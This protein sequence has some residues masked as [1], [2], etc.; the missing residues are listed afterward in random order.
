MLGNANEWVNDWYSE[1]YYSTLAD[2]VVNPQGPDSG[3]TRGIR[4]SC[5]YDENPA[6]IHA[7]FRAHAD[8]VK[9]D[10][11]RCGGFRCGRSDQPD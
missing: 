9:N 4:G 5:Y 6:F 11:T 8:P 2:G 3:T 7:S 10:Q 1:T